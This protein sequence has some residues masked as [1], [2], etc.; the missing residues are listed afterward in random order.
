MLFGPSTPEFIRYVLGIE[1]QQTISMLT[2]FMYHS[3]FLDAFA[4]KSTTLGVLNDI[5]MAFGLIGFTILVLQ[6]SLWTAS[7][8]ISWIVLVGLLI[9]GARSDVLFTPLDQSRAQFIAKLNSPFFAEVVTGL[10][11]AVDS[12]RRWGLVG[13]TQS[14]TSTDGE[15]TTQFPKL[16]DMLKSV[17]ESQQQEVEKIGAFTPM[18]FTLYTFN[19]LKYQL[20]EGLR[21][22]IDVDILSRTGLAQKM[23]ASRLSPSTDQLL[24]TFN[25]LCLRDEQVSRAMLANDQIYNAPESVGR[26]KLPNGKKLQEQLTEQT[27]TAGSLIN[28][29]KNYFNDSITPPATRNTFGLPVPILRTSEGSLFNFDAKTVPPSLLH[30]VAGSGVWDKDPDDIAEDLWQEHRDTIAANSETEGYATMRDNVNRASIADIQEV[31]NIKSD[32]YLTYMLPGKEGIYDDSFWSSNITA[33]TAK[34]CWDLFVAF[35]AALKENF[36]PS[37]LELEMGRLANMQAANSGQFDDQG[38]LTNKINPDA[39]DDKYIAMQALAA[40]TKQQEDICAAEGE[41]SSECKNAKFK[42]NYA[43]QIAEESAVSVA[44]ASWLEKDREFRDP[45][46]QF[47]SSIRNI[48]AQAGELLGPVAVW[49]F[50]LFGGFAA[51]AYSAIIPSFMNFALMMIFA[52]TPFMFMMGVLMPGWAPQIILTPIV[53]VAYIK[54]V[55]IMFVIVGFVFSGLRTGLEAAGLITEQ[56]WFDSLLNGPDVFNAMYDIMVG[57]AYTSMFAV[58]GFMLA[59]IRSPEKLVGGLASYGDKTGRIEGREALQVGTAVVGGF[60]TA[61]HIGNTSIEVGKKGLSGLKAAGGAVVAGAAGVKGFANRI[62]QNRESLGAADF[63][64][65]KEAYDITAG[66]QGDLGESAGQRPVMKPAG[67]ARATMKTV[68]EAGRAVLGRNII[69]VAREKI[70]EVKDSYN[71]KATGVS[72]A[73]ANA[74]ASD[75]GRAAGKQAEAR[76]EGKTANKENVR[77]VAKAFNQADEA[78]PGVLKRDINGVAYKADPV[79]DTFYAK[80]VKA[81]EASLEQGGLS[82]S[83][84]FDRKNETERLVSDVMRAGIADSARNN[85]KMMSQSA[86]FERLVVDAT[87]NVS[88]SDTL[89]NFVSNYATYISQQ[90]VEISAD[91]NLKYTTEIKPT[92]AKPTPPSSGGGR[93]RRKAG[94]R[95]P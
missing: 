44:V 10:D 37:E 66:I 14:Y 68:S 73:L 90:G 2:G 38:R 8:L 51:G 19:R 20:I 52:I 75:A 25:S 60:K 17:V 76:A 50:A 93:K 59:G 61:K 86:D 89:K 91:N 12:V 23:A 94:R 11:N 7:I 34:N 56:G 85:V 42:L 78:D 27:F 62:N 55:E 40:V 41:N 39:S 33:T 30:S 88:Q 28:L 3:L 13:T 71:E 46:R 72:S 21:D 29:Q 16:A 45:S 31:A 63:A 82:P 35:N 58:A 69:T 77:K 47:S 4:G 48:S 53:V 49:F 65:E 95:N 80:L 83:Q 81:V 36:G 43:K 64:K 70:D 1:Q 67:L 57:M 22:D 6:R 84:V 24:Y 18:V 9:L 15:D 26:F 74:G 92:H 32:L 5:I 54:I 79:L 87:I